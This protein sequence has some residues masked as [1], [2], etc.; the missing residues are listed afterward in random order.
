VKRS[1]THQET[2]LSFRHLN[3]HQQLLSSATQPLNKLSGQSPNQRR[4]KKRCETAYE[5]KRN[6]TQEILASAKRKD[7]HE[8]QQTKNDGQLKMGW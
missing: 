6:P 2:V 8:H 5:Q 3:R 4:T 1:G 7:K